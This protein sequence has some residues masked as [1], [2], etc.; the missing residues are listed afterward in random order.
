MWPSACLAVL[1]LS[2]P[3]VIKPFAKLYYR[4]PV[5]IVKFY[6]RFEHFYTAFYGDLIDMFERIVGKQL[7]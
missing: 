6:N 7:C 2:V 4:R 3:H 1:L 5:L